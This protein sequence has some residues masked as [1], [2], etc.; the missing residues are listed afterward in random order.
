MKRNARDSTTERAVVLSAFV[1]HHLRQFALPYL[2]LA[3]FTA[4]A[5]VVELVSPADAEQ[6]LGRFGLFVKGPSDLTGDG[7]GELAVSTTETVGDVK[8]AGSVYILNGQD[9]SLVRRLVAPTPVFP[10][11]FGFV[12]AEAPDLNGDKIPGIVVPSSRANRIFVFSGASGEVL[13]TIFSTDFAP[14]DQ[15]QFNSWAQAIVALGS[16]RS[17]SV[18]TLAVSWPGFD[19][20]TP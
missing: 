11:A 6:E 16:T 14:G 1:H 19:R 18:P 5:Q 20:T 12:L 2:L 17:N 9:F 15:P 8:G 3:H 4:N 13:Q 10:S 7:I